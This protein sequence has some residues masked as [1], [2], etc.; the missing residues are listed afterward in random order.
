ANGGY[1]AGFVESG[2]N[3]GGTIWTKRVSDTSYKIG[4]EVRTS[5]GASTSWTTADYTVGQTY[6]VIV[7][8]DFVA[9]TANDTVRLWVDNTD[10]NSP[11]LTDSHTGTDLASTT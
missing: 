11:T 9:G 7:A 1:F 3:Y 8:Y 5:T 10:L 6:T 2:T 4:I